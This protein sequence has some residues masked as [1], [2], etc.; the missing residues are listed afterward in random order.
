MV[1]LLLLFVC[2]FILTQE[3]HEKAENCLRFISLLS[4]PC[5]ELVNAEPKNIP[6]LLPQLLNIIRVIWLNSE[7]Y[8][9][10]ERLNGLLRKV[11]F[12]N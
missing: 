6:A 11:R 1:M 8:K 10:R 3:S 12:K 2:L 4:E 9:S 5:Q 7:H